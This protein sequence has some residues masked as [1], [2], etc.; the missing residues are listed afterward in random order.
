MQTS[1]IKITDEI[2]RV[3][4]TGG[5][6]YVVKRCSEQLTHSGANSFSDDSETDNLINIAENEYGK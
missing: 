3:F 2:V 1:A 5:T 4:V 6:E